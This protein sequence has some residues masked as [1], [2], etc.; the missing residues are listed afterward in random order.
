MRT[1]FPLLLLGFVG[2]APAA[3]TLRPHPVLPLKTVR[4]YE[5]GV[6]YFE[7][8]GVLPSS[9]ESGLPVPEGHLDDALKTLVV[10]TPGGK[11]QVGGI[12]FKS[13]LSHGMAR[14]L[15]GL[16]QTG[17]APTSTAE[18]TYDEL[19]ASMEGS[20][21]E[22]RTPHGPLVGRL[23]HVEAVTDG[24][25]KTERLRV[26][27][28][29]EH[30]QALHLDEPE[31]QSVRPLD[32]AQAAR[33]DAALESLLSHGQSR[34]AL[35]LLGAPGSPIALGYIAETPVWRTSY[36][37]VIPTG[38]AS[39]LQAWALVHNDTDED[40]RDVHVDLVNGR[41]DSFLF[42]LAAPRYAKRT[43][44]TPQN[45]LSTVPQL[46]GKTADT[47]WGD[48]VDAD[49]ASASGASVSGVGYG[50]GG[51]GSGYGMG[52]GSIGTIGHGSGEGESS[53]LSVG[54]LAGV[55]EATGIEAGALFVY[56]LPS[57]VELRAHAS[58]LVPFMQREVEAE[59]IALIDP[60][61]S[62]VARSAVRLVNSTPQTLPD[63]SIAFF[64]DGGFSGESTIDRLKPHERRFITFGADLDVDAES[65]T[66]STKVTVER[67]TFG[68][69]TLTEHYLRTSDTSW[70][71]ENRSGQPRAVYVTLALRRNAKVSGADATD[72]DTKADK[73]LLVFKLAAQSKIERTIN[74]VEGLTRG[75]PLD[76]LTPAALTALSTT[77]TLRAADRALIADAV[78]PCRELE[79][80]RKKLETAKEQMVRLDK[81][82][83]RLR[84]DAKSIGDHGAIAQPLVA[85][86]VTAEDAVR[87]VRNQSDDL[88]KEVTTRRE[89]LRAALAKLG[90]R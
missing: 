72:F 50:G 49:E 62:S 54:N 47:L 64:A 1:V 77:S 22:V 78:A 3:S 82:L 48:H 44:V 68:G 83:V 37:L 51:S 5:T 23:V 59:R 33:L 53:L 41:P 31:V 24:D 14:A 85:R 84:D 26:T 40:W 79:A 89:T 56:G 69:D 42:T 46:M 38:A 6:G 61:A 66:L 57:A 90:T 30:A 19:L 10:L 60:S 32:A 16:P 21:V 7:R 36:R 28:L 65:E 13:R 29:G 74:S 45:E 12:E 58:A 20:L 27:L 35:R 34:H 15:A 76:G 4:L 9:D 17:D 11:V 39:M 70:K 52:L 25:K 73:P 80:T 63:G 88:E 87:T 8:A 81:D 75:Q 2:C 71:V 55:A 18:I 67:A 86:M 43:L